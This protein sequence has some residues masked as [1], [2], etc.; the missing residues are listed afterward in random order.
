MKIAQLVADLKMAEA[1]GLKRLTTEA[2]HFS[3]PLFARFGFRVTEV[4][5]V[6]RGGVRIDRHRMALEIKRQSETPS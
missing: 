3:R 1:R 5:T 6:E 4:E 2:S